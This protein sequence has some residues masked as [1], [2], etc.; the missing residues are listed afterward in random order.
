MT[1]GRGRALVTLL[2]A[3]ILVS[4]AGRAARGEA[5]PPARWYHGT[6]HVHTAK[7]DG[8]A[9]PDIVA[10]WYHDHGYDF[11]VITDH[12]QITPVERLN[13]VYG[14]GGSFLVMAGEEVTDKL[15]KAPIHM[16]AIGLRQ[17]VPPQGG[18]TA[19]EILERDAQAIRAAGGLPQANH[20]NYLWAWS[21]AELL[22]AP[23]VRHF[24]VFNGHP[25]T[26]SNGGGGT[27]SAEELWDAVLST[28]RVVYGTAGDDAHDFHGELSRRLANPGRAWVAVRADALTPEA[29]VAAL[30]AGRFYASRG[31]EITD[32]VVDERGIRLTLPTSPIWP[33][34]ERTHR[35]DLRYRTTFIGKGG[36]VLRRD[37]TL[38]P[39]YELTGKEL[40]VRARV[41]SSDA[42]VAW[43]QPVFPRLGRPGPE[44]R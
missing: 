16:N 36:T 21:A 20:P 4:V 23:T 32:I 13:R 43:T 40:Y 25:A 29:I 39:H 30:D 17:V 2:A 22:A 42:T 12:D 18:A 1:V 41:E 31:P 19:A 34:P 11:I 5:P 35:F 24:E 28:G 26:N 7:S 27:P 6:M 37:D 44:R 3:L 15:A 38:T 14:D 9:S 8:D 33:A 10:R